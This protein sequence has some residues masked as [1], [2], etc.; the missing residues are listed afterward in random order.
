MEAEYLNGLIK[1]SVSGVLSS[2]GLLVSFSGLWIPVRLA[3][4]PFFAL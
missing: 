2:G 4:D 3:E 1:Y